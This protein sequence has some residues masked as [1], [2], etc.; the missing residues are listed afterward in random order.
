MKWKQFSEEQ[1]IGAAG[2]FG[3]AASMQKHRIDEDRVRPFEQRDA[4]RTHE[5]Q[6]VGEVLF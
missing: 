4:Q 2:V 3:T 5:R 1:I 6:Q